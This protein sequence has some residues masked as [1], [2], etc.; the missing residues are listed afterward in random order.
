MGNISNEELVR[1]AIITTDAIVSSGKLNDVQADKFIDYVID[2]SILKNNARVVRFRSENMNIDKIGIGSRAA[3]AKQEATDPGVRRGVSTSQVVLTPK[4]VMVP[5]EISDTFKDINLEGASVEDTIMKMF[6]KQLAN[7]L[8]ELYLTGD[9]LGH[10]IL[11]ND[12]KGSGSTTQYVKDTFL[13]LQNGWLRIA[14]GGNIVD[15]ANASISLNVFSKLARAMPT[16]FRRDPSKLR[17]FMSPDLYQ[18][19]AEQLASRD[20]NLGDS[21]AGGQKHSPWGIPVVPVPL[22]PHYVPVVEHVT[23]SGTTAASLRYKNLTSE[24]VTPS[25]LANTPTTPYVEGSGND[26]V[27]DGPNGTI[28]RDAGGAISDGQVVKVTYKATPQ[29]IL[30]HMMNFII[31]IGRDI[32]IER[33]RD[34]YKGVDQ[35]AIT[36]KVASTFE[37]NTAIVK[38]TNIKATS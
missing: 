24:V 20:T 23:L 22:L 9:L 18:L 13:A 14:D 1:K 33:D 15:A 10:A 12:L 17:Y 26:Y 35:Y 11:E 6:A 3:V 31:G 30:T 25:T 28:T 16:K 21:V 8:E 19:Y 36:V 27:F 5:F 37:E 2:E 7:D 4:E 38:G 34:I 29:I 32:R